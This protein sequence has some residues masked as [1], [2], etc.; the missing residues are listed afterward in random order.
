MP[1]L[2]WF[3]VH[4]YQDGEWACDK[5]NRFP[6]DGTL[7]HTADCVCGVAEID[8]IAY[9]AYFHRDLD[10]AIVPDICNDYCACVG[11]RCGHKFR[12]PCDDGPIPPP[13]PAQRRL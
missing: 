7:T 12:V 6:L 9:S 3:A 8:I 2:N 5:V 4:F 1:K 13:C 10:Q 11:R